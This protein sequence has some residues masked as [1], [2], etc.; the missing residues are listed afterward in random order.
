MPNSKDKR[1]LFLGIILTSLIFISDVF[2]PVKMHSEFIY[3]IVI[4][5][6]IWTPGN[7]STFDAGIVM[8]VLI[9]IGFY[10]ND[11]KGIGDNEISSIIIPVLSLWS[12]VYVIVRFKKEREKT[13]MSN[14][15]LNAMF[16][17]AT[18]GMI[19]SNTKGEIVMA[20]PHSE[21]MLGYE[22]G[23]LIK[24]TIEKLVPAR[25]AAKH[26]HH[27]NNYYGEMN[28]RPMGKGMSLFACRKDGSEFPV[29]ISLSNFRIKEEAFIISFLID[30]TER[31][32]HEELVHKSNTDL[33]LRVGE[34]TRELA[35]ANISLKEEMEE[36]T[37][38]EEALRDSERLYNT[39]A[40]NFPNGWIEIVDSNLRR[41]FFDGKELQELGINREEFLG[42]SKLE[43]TFIPISN[44][45][46][47]KLAKVFEWQSAN[48]DVDMMSRIYEVNAVPLPDMKG[49]VKEILLVVQNVTDVRRADYETREALNK[50]KQLNELKSKFVSIASHEFRTPLSTILS[51]V[52]LAE[53]Y[54][55]PDDA[56]KR[57]K[58][59]ERIRSSVKNLT[60]ILNDFLSLEK[61]EAGKTECRPEQF[62]IV[63]FA[64]DMKEQMQTLTK[65]GQQI[66][67]AHKG[68]QN[69]VNLDK[70]LLRNICINLIGNAIKYSPEG[71]SIEF[72]TSVNSEVKISVKDS[73]I[74]IPEIDK[75]HMF[76][77]FFRAHN[78][79]AIQ[80]T[81]LGLNIVNRYVKLMKGKME[82]TSKENAGSEFI[83][84]FN[85]QNTT[86]Q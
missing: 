37:R 35:E 6:S 83:V 21:E 68:S 12:F 76:E 28:T 85:I 50:E 59:F 15:Y 3:A 30:I 10:L 17:N 46:K 22:K 45:I 5:I 4:L 8:T 14:E 32:K 47:D 19:I 63:N 49:I 78:V 24:L 73:G 25:L 54:S 57:T 38:M 9:I 2:L 43:K 75:Q 52:S 61:L 26:V 62:D 70:Q 40:H 7:R 69:L 48:F 65:P 84:R 33:E 55:A 11:H 29:E 44:E 82:F 79:T 18:E 72:T 60:E 53:K 80:G 64:E 71:K 66:V 13:A 36:R 31:K 74:G 86:N 41:V 27:R 81:G 56:E 23:E 16:I 1:I 39:M 77:R 51:S 58:H 20:N 67:Y 42:K 34:R